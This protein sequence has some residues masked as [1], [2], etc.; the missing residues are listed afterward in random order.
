VW[1]AQITVARTQVSAAAD[2]AALAAVRSGS[3]DEARRVARRNGA[4]LESCV[5]DGPD[6]QVVTV[7]DMSLFGRSLPVRATAR[8]GY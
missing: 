5:I 3:C 6:F 8:A 2:L 4:G 1:V 7:I